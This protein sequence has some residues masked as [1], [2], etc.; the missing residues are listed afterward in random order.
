MLTTNKSVRITDFQNGLGQKTK[1]IQEQNQQKKTRMAIMETMT[2]TTT[3]KQ[4]LGIS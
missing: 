4:D 2:A 1:F 3:T